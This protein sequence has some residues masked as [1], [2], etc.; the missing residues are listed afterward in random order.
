MKTII[1]DAKEV[2]E[3]V[4]CDGTRICQHSSRVE[5]TR[6]LAGQI[7][8]SKAEIQ[9]YPTTDRN[10]ALTLYNG[11]GIVYNNETARTSSVSRPVPHVCCVF[12]KNCGTRAKKVA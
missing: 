3:C 2:I 4:H 9:Y 12:C 11:C 10:K 5:L 1:V 8:T 7:L 6:Q